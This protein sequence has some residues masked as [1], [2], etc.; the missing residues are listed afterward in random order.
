[1]RPP[2]RVDGAQLSLTCATSPVP[3]FGPQT[4][5]LFVFP[6]IRYIIEGIQEEPMRG[7]RTYMADLPAR[8]RR[9]VWMLALAAPAW[10]QVTISSIQSSLV[11]ANSPKNVQGITSAAQ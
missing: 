4:P 9:M 10:S 6:R 7:E 2:K 8:L 1:M 3:F 5:A 11:G